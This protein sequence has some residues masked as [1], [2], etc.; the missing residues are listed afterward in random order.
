MRTLPAAQKN[1]IKRERATRGMAA[2]IKLA[3]RLA[4]AA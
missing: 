1:R 4:R 3:Q 2:A